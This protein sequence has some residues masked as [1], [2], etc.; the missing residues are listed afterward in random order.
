[1]SAIKITTEEFVVR[2]NTVHKN[3]YEYPTKYAGSRT[4]I[5]V[6]CPMH[7]IFNVRAYS[8]LEGTGCKLC[9]I[10]HRATQNTLTHEQFLA[11][12]RLIHGDRYTY[13]S[14]YVHSQHKLIIKC[15]T[16]G[17]FNQ[18]P[19]CHL[20]GSGCYRCRNTRSGGQTKRKLKMSGGHGMY[21]N[22][23][24]NANPLHKRIP[25][26]FYVARIIVNDQSLYKIGITKNLKSR[27]ANYNKT[28]QYL[29]TIKEKYDLNLK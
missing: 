18:T 9:D 8:H 15:I 6:I 25:A 17:T 3:R 1:M 16:H 24:F 5:D 23:Y 7:G 19:T 14:T 29:T 2:A 21:S 11:R 13:L 12:A 10:T 4:L 26:H 20:Q 28:T 27:I 22:R